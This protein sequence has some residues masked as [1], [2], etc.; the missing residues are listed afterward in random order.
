MFNHS[1][2]TY[3]KSNPNYTADQQPF[4]FTCAVYRIHPVTREFQVFAEG[5]SNQWGIAYN[6][7]GE[8][9][10]SAC[11]IDHL[12]HVTQT[13]YYIRQGG[14]YPP[15][16]WPMKSIVDYTHQKAAYCGIHWSDTD[17]W[18]EE[19]RNVLFM[20]NIHGNCVNTDALEPNG[21]TY[22]GVKKPDFLT[23]NDVWFMPV[24][25]KTGPDGSLYVL[26]WYDR[27]HC[28]QDANRDPEG[29][30][31]GH[32]RLYRVRYGD[33]PRWSGDLAE[34]SDERLIDLLDG[35]NEWVRD[36]ARRLLTERL[37]EVPS[38]P[39]AQARDQR[40]G[41]PEDPS[42]ARRAGIDDLVSSLSSLVSSDAPRRQRLGALYALVGGGLSV[43]EAWRLADHLAGHADPAFRV[44]GV[45]CV[46]EHVL[47][48]PAPDV[49][50]S[51]RDR[52]LGFLVRAA[53][54]ADPAVR[55]QAA[56]AAGE[57]VRAE[58]GLIPPVRGVWRAILAGTSGPDAGDD[59][60]LPRLVWA[61]L[62]P[63]LD[64]FPGQTVEDLTASLSTPGTGAALAPILPR[65]IDKLLGTGLRTDP[66]FARLIDTVLKGDGVSDAVRADTLALLGD[67]VRGGAADD[68]ERTALRSTLADTL[69]T[70]IDEGSDAVRF[71][72]VILAAGLGLEP[73]TSIARERLADAGVNVYGRQ[74]FAEAL[75]AAGDESV[76][77][78][79]AAALADAD[80]PGELRG[81]LVEAVGRIDSPR[82]AD[83]L[84]AA[85]DRLPA[86]L[87]P[88]VSEQLTRRGAWAH[89][90]LDA[91]SAGTIPKD[92]LNL[93]QI[94]RLLASPAEE[95]V[96]QT[97]SI[98][99]TVREGRDPG[100]EQVIAEVERVLA[101]REGD[102]VRGKTV[103][104]RVC[105]QCHK[106]Y[107]EG[108]EVG[109][110]LTNNGRNDFRQLLSNVYDPNLVIGAAYRAHTVV[111]EDGRVL[112]GLLVEDGAERVVL[113]VQGGKQEVIPRS[114][115][116]D[117][118][119]AALSLMPEGLEKQMTP[120]QTADLFAYLRTDGPLP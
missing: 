18:P 79:V 10:L 116:L 67:R 48:R 87:R 21:A 54:D 100:R 63:Q 2:V 82:V 33:A 105:G 73:G 19:W 72:A 99:G 3:P 77:D 26:D 120:E 113:K 14:P 101:N 34:E 97:R 64:R 76:L 9:F 92:S 39:D 114:A 11:V 68:A 49:D 15:H 23:A 96:N 57:A 46:T 95:I 51:G 36:T 91:I 117:E 58:A 52:L 17:G 118:S 42:L 85:W 78:A 1:S 111:T 108:A 32:G 110:D 55:R 59:P 71:R 70:L 90:L 61:N 47:T 107:G 81:G 74:A 103:F 69:R 12:W 50:G 98:Y 62:Q 84:L 75:V 60:L 27:Y 66:R 109:P 83:V 31:R 102:A 28:Y 56:V 24:A 38:Q 119:V 40:S 80:T 94:R 115:I 44:W 35:P 89:A 93:T 86:D 20:G 4:D 106:L 112:S 8:M 30:D 13:G 6:T 16:T 65:V 45:R 37:A 41:S 53:G 104:T 29:V 25:Q 7:E 22:Q 5:M 88:K 43:D